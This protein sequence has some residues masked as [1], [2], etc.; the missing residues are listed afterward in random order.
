MTE[1]ETERAG[2]IAGNSGEPV[3]LENVSLCGITAEARQGPGEVSIWVRMAMDSDVPHFQII[4]EG[5]VG[6]LEGFLAAQG[7]SAPLRS[8]NTI[9]L[10]LRPDD[11]A[12]LWVDTAARTTSVRVK[13]AMSGG[14]PVFERD[15]ADI[16][17]MDF[18][19]VDIGPKDR[20]VCIFRVNW[21]FGLF[22][23]LDTENDLDR[24]RM[25]RVLG[26]LYR[27]LRYR[28]LYE[29]TSDGDLLRVLAD[30]GW[31]P[32]VEIMAE[33]KSLASAAKEGFDLAPAEVELLARFDK[34]RL[35]TMFTRWMT[36]PHFTSKEAL[37]RSAI[38]TYL[39]NEPAAVIK[40]VLTE[41]EGI[42]AA[43]YRTAHGKSAK[44][45]E[46]IRFA[47]ETAAQQAGSTDTL[48][49]PAVFGQYLANYTFAN[50]DPLGPPGT[51]GSRHA[52][53][54]GAADT[55]TYTQVRALQALL[56]LDQLSFYIN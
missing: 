6:A 11:S 45:N 29:I 17:A 44:T 34:E 7:K 53:G 21:R 14:S 18:P 52:V 26:N 56:T 43:A 1:P 2:M 25:R 16:T 30:A 5:I 22:F 40:I 27:T 48:L 3:R 9:L 12:E 8:A 41:I 4:V 51:A 32:F 38:N 24:D 42:L 19:L 36:Q 23:H 37:L 15:I 46:L 20:V 28:H 54:H 47:L 13:R 55:A 39:T 10:V 33:F 49:L 50:F 31:F 35:E